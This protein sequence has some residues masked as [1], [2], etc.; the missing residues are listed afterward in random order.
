MAGGE[1][2]GYSSKVNPQRLQNLFTAVDKTGGRK[3]A[4]HN[5][6]GLKEFAAIGSIVQ[7]YTTYTEVDAGG[8]LTVAATEITLADVEH[9][10]A[11]YVY[12]DF[13]AGYFDGDF[14]H[15]FKLNLS[16]ID[17]FAKED[18]TAYTEVDAGGVLTVAAN[19]ITF[20]DLEYQDTAYVYKDFGANYFSGDF[21]HEFKLR[22]TDFTSGPF[23]EGVV[24]PWYLSNTLA[25]N[26]IHDS[27]YPHL[28]VMAIQVSSTQWQFY[29]YEVTSGGSTYWDTSTYL[30][31]NT[32]YYC[33]VNRDESVGTYGTLYLYIYSDAAM[34]TLVDTVSFALHQK[35][36]FRYLYGVNSQGRSGR[37]AI[38]SGNVANLFVDGQET[39]YIYPWMM[40]NVVAV[41]ATL[42]TN[43]DDYLA[44]RAILNSRT[45]YE[46]GLVERNG[47]APLSGSIAGSTLDKNTNYYCQ[48]K[49]EDSWGTY[50]RLRFS[51][52]TDPNYSILL[53]SANL[54]LSE[55]EDFRYLFGFNSQGAAS[56]TVKA[57]GTVEDLSIS[58][59]QGTVRGMRE[60]EGDFYAAADNKLYKVTSA[61]VVSELGT[62]DTS[63]G[64]V[65]FADNGDYVMLVDGTSGYTY[66]I[67]TATFAKI[68]DA[69]FPTPTSVTY[70]DAYFIVSESGTGNFYIS[71]LNDP[72]SWNALDYDNAMGDPDDTV[73]AISNQSDLWLL[74]AASVEVWWNSGNADFPFELIQ[75]SFQSVGI[76][77]RA[78]AVILGSSLLWFTDDRR[79]VRTEGYAIRPISPPQVEYQWGTYATV[80]DAVAV[81][82]VL[83][84]Q[85]WYVLTFPIQGVSWGY[86]GTTGE[87]NIWASPPSAGRWRGNCH[88]ELSGTHYAGD[89]ENGKIYQ[90]DTDTYT[91]DGQTIQRIR[92]GPP[93]TY[94]RFGFTVHALELEIQ[95]G[96]GRA[97]PPSTAPEVLLEYSK[98]GGENFVSTGTAQMGEA[99]E[100][101][102]RLIWR[103]LGWMREF[104]Y[105]LTVE[106]QVKV[107]LVE[108]FA[109]V[110]V[111]DA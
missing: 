15:T 11:A 102:Q 21:T 108:L 8:L 43:N 2:R 92:T 10:D 54:T 74:G 79:V 94:G 57:S 55:K 88:A 87:W 91:D 33:R 68:T 4:L 9:R 44:L 39:A 3:V 30:S 109:D 73:R 19:Q 103:R 99:G 95:A 51:I 76:G 110:E 84:G 71:A 37:T 69:D 83:E 20:T 52:F 35:Q 25:N 72:T 67:S 60:V 24:F 6:P 28:K 89:F 66:R 29:L 111:F 46:L 36:D 34:T 98:D 26:E 45:T 61:G 17:G 50:G 104:V 101:T 47:S 85:E 75:G 82:F 42:D 12:K 107:V 100:T 96:V 32:D 106:E 90:I 105:R 31:K 14:V 58:G 86:N 27:Y 56:G 77:A 70:Q 7:D 62:L 53:A 23:S 16:N 97:T 49:R 59:A 65:Y 18:Y 80:S 64:V 38:I 13:T 1:S 41:A 48:V 63:T 78:S 40:T 5:T 22:I 81:G 93:L